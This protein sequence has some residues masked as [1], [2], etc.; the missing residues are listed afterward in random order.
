MI[1]KHVF[2]MVRCVHGQYSSD[3][4]QTNSIIHT[5]V[6]WY[7]YYVV[8]YVARAHS[9]TL[10]SYKMERWM[11]EIDLT[12][13]KPCKICSRLLLRKLESQLQGG[14]RSR[15]VKKTVT[16]DHLECETLSPFF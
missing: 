2:V 15:L 5:V 8:A 3:R 1:F 4:L 10:G 14:G 11:T 9:C 6:N 7:S 12:F 13:I 16:P